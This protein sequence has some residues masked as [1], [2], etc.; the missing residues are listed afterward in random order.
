MFLQQERNR[1]IVM[2]VINLSR[3]K[4]SSDGIE[5]HIRVIF[6]YFK[7]QPS[8][9][10]SFVCGVMY[11]RYIFT[12]TN[13]EYSCKEC[14]KLFLRIA[15][16]KVH[17]QYHVRGKSFRCDHCGNRFHAETN[18]KRHIAAIHSGALKF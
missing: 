12:E 6:L 3:P 16:L 7:H 18:L 2:T 14:G 9:A 15:S 10:Y 5:K 17:Q 4:R 8:K 11:E 13:K 1:S